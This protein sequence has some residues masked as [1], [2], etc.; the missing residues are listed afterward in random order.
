MQLKETAF[1]HVR[2]EQWLR[3]YLSS[4]YTQ[5]FLLIYVNDN[6]SS[7]Q[8][9]LIS[10]FYCESLKSES[11]WDHTVIMMFNFLILI[12][13]FFYIYGAG[14]AVRC[15]VRCSECCPVRRAFVCHG[16]VPGNDGASAL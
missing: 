15:S 10:C 3:I 13:T 11:A 7:L 9:L 5:F 4:I 14:G 8:I 2:T 6:F 16:A 12:S 1:F